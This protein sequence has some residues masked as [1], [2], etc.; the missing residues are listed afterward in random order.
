MIEQFD[1]FHRDSDGGT[2]W[3]W[4][5]VATTIEDAKEQV[6]KL[7]VVNPG[8]YMIFDQTREI[9]TF[10]NARAKARSAFGSGGLS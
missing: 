6:R 1:I 9:K 8:E 5:Q 2:A 3:R 10:I 4:L 7:S